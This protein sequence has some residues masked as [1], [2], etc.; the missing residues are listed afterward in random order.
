[1]FLDRMFLT[2]W[3]LH[4]KIVPCLVDIGNQGT[5]EKRFLVHRVWPKILPRANEKTINYGTRI[6][7]IF[8]KVERNLS[9]KDHRICMASSLVTIHSVILPLM[10]H[11]IVMHQ[12]I[13]HVNHWCLFF[14]LQRKSINYGTR[15]WYNSLE[16]EKNSSQWD[17]RICMA[18]RRV[19]IHSSFFPL[20]STL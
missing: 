9:Q 15:I 16:V 14:N 8:L 12:G 19:T 13:L 1:M 20:W 10:E 18:S 5:S 6:W 11:I 4:T 2:V 17:H 3:C 7:Y